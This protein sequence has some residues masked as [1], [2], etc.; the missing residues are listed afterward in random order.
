VRTRL[1]TGLPGTHGLASIQSGRRYFER[2]RQD[3]GGTGIRVAGS[4]GR[5]GIDSANPF[6]CPA[7]AI[8][9]PADSG[10]CATPCRA[11]F[12][13]VCYHHPSSC[14]YPCFGA[15][16]NHFPVPVCPHRVDGGPCKLASPD[17]QVHADGSYH[18]CRRCFGRFLQPNLGIVSVNV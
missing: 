10:E 11:C 16:S 14:K 15:V 2:F 3:A 12:L 18:G 7:P 8:R 9:S 1:M 4:Q 5:S 6:S 13:L 17:H